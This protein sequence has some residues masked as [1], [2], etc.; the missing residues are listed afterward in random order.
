MMGL[1]IELMGQRGRQGLL[2]Y[3]RCRDPAIS[4]RT[5]NPGVIQA[6]DVIDDTPVLG[7][8]RGGG[9]RRAP[10]T[11]SHPVCPA[12]YPFW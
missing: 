4:D 1:V 5:G 10:Q 7:L 2:E 11:G 9:V 6:V 3:F 8:A 12:R